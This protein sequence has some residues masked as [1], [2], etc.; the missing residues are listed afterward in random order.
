MRKLPVPLALVLLLPLLLLLLLLRLDHFPFDIIF[1]SL[2][3][4]L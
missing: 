1:F 3:V 2:I 4:L